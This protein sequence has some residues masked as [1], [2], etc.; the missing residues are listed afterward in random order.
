MLK[1]VGPLALVCALVL[2]LGCSKQASVANDGKKGT[3]TSTNNSNV[4]APVPGKS[5]DA[6]PQID[7][8]AAAL[9]IRDLE[10]AWKTKCVTHVAGM[11]PHVTLYRFDAE[12]TGLWV[13]YHYSQSD[14]RLSSFQRRSA[15]DFTFQI[16]RKSQQAEGF[17]EINYTYEDGTV[18]YNIIAINAGNA[19]LMYDG[20]IWTSGLDG[21]SE[22]LRPV[23]GDF[24]YEFVKQ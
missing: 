2:S 1:L 13:R 9:T 17:H 11:G 21:S 24:R 6:Q 8:N 10:G 3:T 19:N 15:A 20:N 12:G 4:P 14:C 16:V 22:E 23:N 18:E 7:P 5:G